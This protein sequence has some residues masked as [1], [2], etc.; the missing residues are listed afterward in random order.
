M[1]IYEM[2]KSPPPETS[3]EVYLSERRRSSTI[4]AKQVQQQLEQQSTF[5][6]NYNQRQQYFKDLNRKLINQD[7]KLLNVVANRGQIHRHSVDI[8]QLPLNSAILQG[9]KAL[10]KEASAAAAAAA[11]AA[12]STGGRT[13]T[14]ATAAASSSSQ[15]AAGS[16]APAEE[17][18]ADRKAINQEQQQAKLNPQQTAAEADHQDKTSAAAKGLPRSNPRHLVAIRENDP[19][20]PIIDHSTAAAAAAAASASGKF[21]LFIIRVCL[22]L[23]QSAG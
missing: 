22:C 17:D 11:A 3:L 18:S 14:S 10:Q 1:S 2:T 20:S 9:N 15:L 8:A 12:D 16:A 21:D 5:Q 6:T 13:L 19:F 7:K 4:S 23:F